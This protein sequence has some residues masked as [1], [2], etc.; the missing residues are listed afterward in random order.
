MGKHGHRWQKKTN[1]DGKKKKFRKAHN[2]K[3]QWRADLGRKFELTV[4]KLLNRM[5]EN[6]KLTSSLY[7]Q[8]NSSADKQG[9]DFTVTQISKNGEKITHSFGVTISYQSWGRAKLKHPDVP[10]FYFPIGTRFA[11][12]EETILNLFL[13]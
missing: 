5:V 7:N 9:K 13:S 11:T 8:P 3:A 1:Q 4:A 12:I 6:N 10:Q 2:Q